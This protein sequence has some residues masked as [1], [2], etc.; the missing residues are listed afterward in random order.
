MFPS[1]T[2][3]TATRH[4]APPA[5]SQ[6]S[7]VSP[8]ST[9]SL[10][11]LGLQAKLPQ[12]RPHRLAL[13]ANKYLTA[14]SFLS[15]MHTPNVASSP[16]LILNDSQLKAMFPQSPLGIPH[17]TPSWGNFS[18]T[19]TTP[20]LSCDPC[21]IDMSDLMPILLPNPLASPQPPLM[22]LGGNS[23]FE[24]MF[25]ISLAGFDSPEGQFGA[26]QPPQSHSY[27]KSSVPVHTHQFDGMASN[28]FDQ[29]QQQQQFSDTPFMPVD[30]YALD[31]W[32][33]DSSSLMLDPF[34]SYSVE[35]M[36]ASPEF[37]LPLLVPTTT[38]AP[39]P[40]P[41]SSSA[42]TFSYDSVS[43]DSI[44]CNTRH[45]SL[46]PM[47]APHEPAAAASASSTPAALPHRTSPQ[48][49]HQ[50]VRSRSSKLPHSSTSLSNRAASLGFDDEDY[51]ATTTP[52][53]THSSPSA[54][55]AESP[56][57]FG[58]E[59]YKNNK[60]FRL[61]KEQMQRLKDV[62]AENPLPT[63]KEAEEIAREIK[64]DVVKIKIWFQ[65]RR[66]AT[67]RRMKGGH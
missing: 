50:P 8:D 66:A 55:R 34:A 44:F 23:G 54:S 64:V 13:P 20:E 30:Q 43:M 59:S 63:A 1:P 41:P 39:T 29:L 2:P 62:F 31:S 51:L 9:V 6:L 38:F 26:S 35:P 45:D 42:S 18:A 28:S 32:L 53:R 7:P 58:K 37:S 56:D 52:K 19:F 22:P 47:S 5:P 48:K 27:S 3:T 15:P 46:G 21:Y 16:A 57:D 67:K 17:A 4:D 60:R 65:N 49:K 11:S 24:S 12:Q 36:L 61:P 14:P 40:L 33:Y 25:E 10:L